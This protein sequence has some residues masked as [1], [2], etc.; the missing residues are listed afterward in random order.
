MLYMNRIYTNLVYRI[1]SRTTRDD[2]YSIEVLN[3]CKFKEFLEF[4]S[5]AWLP[6]PNG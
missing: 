5:P 3:V 2:V 6:T 1:F 4:Q